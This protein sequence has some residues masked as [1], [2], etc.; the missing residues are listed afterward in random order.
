MKMLPMKH[1]WWISDL[2]HDHDQLTVDWEDDDPGN[3][4]SNDANT[5]QNLQQLLSSR[6]KISRVDNIDVP[7]L[8]LLVLEVQQTD[9][10][11]V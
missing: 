5:D 3:N 9:F 8:C 11:V 10:K 4:D 6:S 7:L 1:D 2:D